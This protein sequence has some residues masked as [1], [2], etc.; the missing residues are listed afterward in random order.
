M[1]IN[2]VDNISDNLIMTTNTTSPQKNTT[3]MNITAN[4]QNKINQEY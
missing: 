1:I 4:H 3:N 2:T